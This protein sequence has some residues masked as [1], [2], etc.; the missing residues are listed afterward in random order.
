MLSGTLMCKSDLVGLNS[1]PDGADLQNQFRD[2]V[3]PMPA[4]SFEVCRF[5]EKAFGLIRIPAERRGPCVLTKDYGSL[6][7]RTVYFRRDSM[8]D[9]AT[10]E[11]VAR[12]VG[13]VQNPT[14]PIETNGEE[15]WAAFLRST[16]GFSGS[17]RFILISAIAR[18]VF[19]PEA[20]VL[21]AVPW[22]A[23]IDL[24]PHSETSGLLSV[25]TRCAAKHRSLHKLVLS[26]RV[27]INKD[28]TTYWIF[29]RGLDG[30]AA[31]MADGS[32]REWLKHSQA[33]L[34]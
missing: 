1:F 21:G 23:V 4:F 5:G 30:R 24:D 29:A 33:D 2:K 25:A 27:T 15:P 9:I 19:I 10:P 16:Q 28:H 34:H 17:Q 7:Q 20:G 12:I 6:R 14:T 8:N 11:E 22:T 32:W 13:W 31:T 26:D 18:D 3:H